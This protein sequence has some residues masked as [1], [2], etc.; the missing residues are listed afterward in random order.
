MHQKT[1]DPEPT[2]LKKSQVSDT[3][4]DQPTN[5]ETTEMDETG[6]LPEQEVTDKELQEENELENEDEVIPDDEV[7]DLLQSATEP[8]ISKAIFNEKGEQVDT[9]E[10][11]RNEEE[12]ARPASMKAD[13][14]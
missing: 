7:K 9:V 8:Y 14:A 3:T 5:E 1:I 12:L 10:E 13:T 2:S 4:T 6:N 11:A